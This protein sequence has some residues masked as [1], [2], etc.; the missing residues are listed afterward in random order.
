MMKEEKARADPVDRNRWLYNK[1]ARYAPASAAD[2]AASYTTTVDLTDVEDAQYFGPITIG[3]PPQSFSVVF[4]TGSSNLWVPSA[5][6]P[7]ND[8]ACQRHNQYNHNVSSTYVPNGEEFRI[9]YGSGALAGYLSEDTVGLG[10]FVIVNQTFAEA[11]QEPGLTFVV[12]A[13]DGIMGMAFE[14][15]SV[16]HVTPVWYNILDQGLVQ[17]AVFSFWLSKDATATPGGELFLGGI[18]KSRYTGDITYVPLTS[19]TYWEFKM[20]QVLL[21]GASLGWCPS[22]GCP[23]IA[24]TG[25][26][27]ITGPTDLINALNE[28]LGAIVLLGEGIFPSCDNILNNGPDITIV[29]NGHEFVLTP[30]DYVLQETSDGVTE[31][32]SGFYGLDFPTDEGPLYILGDVFISTYYAIFDFDNEQVGFATAV[33]N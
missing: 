31:C 24:D 22:S 13:F 5:T 6:C 33:Q 3:T 28:E 20:D 14:T 21:S 30:Y 16:D 29:L 11:T 12:A 8:I 15:I 4:D 1:Y 18:D 2:A 7:S 23:A 17:D 19:E 10:E 25:T 9:V 26:S 27:L 32:V